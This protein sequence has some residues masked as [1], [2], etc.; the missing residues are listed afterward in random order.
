VGFG[1]GYVFCF[2]SACMVFGTI[3]VD[4]LA[5]R[6]LR[7]HIVAASRNDRYWYYDTHMHIPMTLSPP[8]PVRQNLAESLKAVFTSRLHLVSHHPRSPVPT[9]IAD[10]H[11]LSGECPCLCRLVALNCTLKP[12][13]HRP[14][15]H[16]LCRL[17]GRQDQSAFFPACP[18]IAG[19][20]PAPPG[21]A[22]PIGRARR[23]AV[24]GCPD[25]PRWL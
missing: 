4:A 24:L 3:L 8:G 21:H 11:V 23:P 9:G 17:Q 20:Y 19:S 18:E 13:S 6:W 12:D 15:D 1:A 14:L 22:T 7:G 5:V 2:G 10:P 16:S 25:D